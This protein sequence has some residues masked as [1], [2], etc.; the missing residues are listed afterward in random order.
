MQDRLRATMCWVKYFTSSSS[1]KFLKIKSTYRIRLLF[2]TPSSN[3]TSQTLKGSYRGVMAK[4]KLISTRLSCVK[5]IIP[6]FAKFSQSWKNSPTNL[7]FRVT[8]CS[9]LT[10]ANSSKA[11]SNT[12]APTYNVCRRWL[13]TITNFSG[14]KNQSPNW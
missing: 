8:F 9:V 13:W 6:L 11:N 3:F 7:Y 14:L 10:R 1:V 5:Y 12:T 4:M 2:S